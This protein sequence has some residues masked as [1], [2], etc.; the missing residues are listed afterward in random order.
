MVH[1]ETSIFHIGNKGVTQTA[2]R[3]KTED[4]EEPRESF[5]PSSQGVPILPEREKLS[6][7][8]HGLPVAPRLTGSQE[9]KETLEANGLSDA[10]PAL[11]DAYYFA[12]KAHLHQKRDDG[13]SYHHHCARVAENAVTTF[14]M[15]DLDSLRAALLHDVLE[16]TGVTE[17]ELT[18]KFGSRT[19]FLVKALTKPDLLPGETYDA[20]NRRMLDNIEATGSRELIALK[21]ADRLDNVEDTHLM[22]DREKI[23]RYLADSKDNYVPL[24]QRHFPESAQA[25]S[26][27][28]Q[29][30]ERWLAS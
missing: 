10:W 14:G 24:A 7:I 8:S 12:K 2:L 28:I 9:L 5:T 13:T 16:D 4:S 30:I 27:Q 22:P 21:L 3:P 17:A 23:T 11:K 6:M 18:K 1:V 29:K 20:R 19:T 15:R 25:F 26:G